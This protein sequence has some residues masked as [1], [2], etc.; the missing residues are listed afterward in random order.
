MRINIL[1]RPRGQCLYMTSFSMSRE[2]NVAPGT[3]FFKDT[4]DGT[5]E[6]LM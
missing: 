3:S 5:K 6:S 1:Q 2:G 4:K